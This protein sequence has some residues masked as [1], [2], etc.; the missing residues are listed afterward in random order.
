MK[1][2]VIS[3][4]YPP[5]MRGGAEVIAAHE[6]EGLKAAWQHVFVISSKPRQIKIGGFNI[7][8]DN[9]LVWQD[10]VNGVSI[11][12]INPLNIY[13]Y[14]DDYKFPKIIR[15]L[16]H[17]FDIFNFWSYFKVKKILEEE[18]PE[19]VIT[20]NLMGL[21]FLIPRLIKNLGIKHV[22]TLHDVQLVTPS[23][24]IIRGQEKAW[25][26]RFSDI[27]GYGKLMRK[28]WGSPDIVISP[29]RWLLDFYQ[30]R[31]FFSKSRKIVLPNPV[32]EP[33]DILKKATPNLELLYLGQ[34]NKAKGVLDLIKAVRQLNLPHLRLHMV[35]L[36]TDL[37]LAKAAAQGDRR[38]IWHGW[39]PHEKLAPI[40]QQMDVLVVPSLCYENSP[41]VIYEALSLGLPVLASNIGGVAE[42]IKGGINGWIFPAGDFLQLSQKINML[43]QQRDRLKL[44][45]PA[46]QQSIASFTTPNYINNLLAFLDEQD[47]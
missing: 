40:L 35:G 18:K 10:E 21:G 4:L 46:C 19:V 3:N 29:S 43:Y 9:N 33:I 22:H 38:I 6:A 17:L 41:T 23:G 20:H 16:W 24:L 2:A 1:F 12:R 26:H 7:K 47:K 14:L 30:Q 44:M 25:P 11:Y 39:L 36:G 13:Y 28:L 45:A 27:L 15:L 32:D 42:L 31:D 5:L 8:V 37:N 34:I